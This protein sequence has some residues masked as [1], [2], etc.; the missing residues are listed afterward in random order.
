M[1]FMQMRLRSD[2]S[3]AAS[4]K[5][6]RQSSCLRMS[7]RSTKLT[8]SCGNDTSSKREQGVGFGVV[9]AEVSILDHALLE[10]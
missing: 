9:K 10:M 3:N 4:L 1:N 2:A 5:S 6:P 8:M 7:I